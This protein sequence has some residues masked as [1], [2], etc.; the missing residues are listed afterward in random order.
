MNGKFKP[1]DGADR[2]RVRGAVAS[3]LVVEAGA[4]TGKTTLL[5]DRILT[6]LTKSDLTEI[7]AITFTEKAAG[8]LQ[9]RIRQR[10]EEALASQ[11]STSLREHLVD[12]LSEIDTAQF[13]TIHSFAAT[14][15]RENALTLGW[16]PE[17]A[18]VEPD[19][20]YE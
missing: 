2:R 20:E 4:G 11:R 18:L 8:E 15:I 19:R 6:L 10:I 17:F 13:S 7:A 1:P 14:I 16:D 12:A 9:E 3:S 5:V